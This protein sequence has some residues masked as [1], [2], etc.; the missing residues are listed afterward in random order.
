MEIALSLHDTSY[1]TIS[2][3]GFWGKIA[4]SGTQGGNIHPPCGALPNEY[5]WAERVDSC[6]QL[7]PGVQ[8]PKDDCF[9]DWSPVSHLVHQGN[10]SNPRNPFPIVVMSG[11][12][13]EKW[14]EQRRTLPKTIR[15]QFPFWKMNPDW[16][17]NDTWMTL[18]T[19]PWVMASPVR[20]H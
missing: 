9:L 17:C 12:E 5:Q 1:R 15:H 6:T 4:C 8:G 10:E 14:I 16:S 11:R 13:D 18:G 19:D 2:K 3:I 20:D 7:C